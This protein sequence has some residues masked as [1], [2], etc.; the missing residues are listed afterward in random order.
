MK[1][2]QRLAVVCGMVI[3]ASVAGGQ[4]NAEQRSKQGDAV[5][6]ARQELL[7]AYGRLPL[8]LEPNLGQADPEISFISRANGYTLL[9]TRRAEA[10]LLVEKTDQKP[11]SA[12]LRDK[13]TEGR[14]YQRC[15]RELLRL[16]FIGVKASPHAEA[17]EQLSGRAN[18]FIG[19]DPHKWRTNVPLYGRVKMHD[20]YPGID[21]AYYGNQQQLEQDI[22]VA[23]GADLSAVSMIAMGAKGLSLDQ[24]GNLVVAMQDGDVLLHKPVAYQQIQGSR[25]EVPAT[26]LL[27]AGNKFNFQVA[28][29]DHSHALVIDPVLTYS[30][31]VGGSQRDH[32]DAIAVDS[33]GSAYITGSTSSSDFPVAGALQG[34]LLNSSFGNAFVTKFNAT[35]SALVYSTYLGGTGGEQG[36]GI[37]VDSSGNAYVSGSTGSTDF[38]TTSGAFQT[39]PGTSYVA[40]LNASGSALVYSTYLGNGGGVTA[41]SI[42]V[43][44]S[45]Q[46]FVTGTAVLGYL[47]TT[48][49]AFQTNPTAGFNAFVTKFNSTGTALVYSTYLG[50]SFFVTQGND[51]AIDSAGNAYLTG[52]TF[53]GSFPTTANAFQSVNRSTS[54]GQNAFVSKLNAS[55]SALVWSTYLGGTV[56]DSG[57][58]VAADSS[59][60]AYVTGLANSPDF[61]TTAGSFLTA[62]PVPGTPVGFVSKL[63]STGSAL[64]YST[65]LGGTDAF[66]TIPHR[67][68]VD[69]SANAYV[70]GFTGQAT[71]PVTAN[72]VQATLGGDDDSF[73]TTL[74]PSG[75][76]LVFSSY[77]GGISEDFGADIAL[78]SA[79]SAYIAGSTFSN[80]GF[81]TTPGAFASSTLGQQ[82]GFVAKIADIAP[83]AQLNNLTAEVIVSNKLHTTAIDGRFSP[84]GSIDPITQSVF[85]SV[86]GSNNFAV[87]FSPGSFKRV[88][89]G[90]IASALS[91]SRK[92]TMLLVPLKNGSWSYSALIVGFVPGS[93]PVTVSLTVG[94]QSGSATVTARVF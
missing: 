32:A 73:V 2:Y 65:Y 94:S 47:P 75:T 15:S 14:T 41:N 23:P 76:A 39:T 89:G 40:K 30:T 19:S 6:A 10:V 45:G 43:D 38:P 93:N 26:Y 72:A 53:D 92:I 68:R 31:L 34:S 78:D 18:Y 50:G 49:G 54:S 27:T 88:F 69:S 67:I 20:L 7:R 79:G 64:A 22:I 3:L 21:V 4:V 77:L 63:S 52:S 66:E 55:G 1:T 42:A 29:Y 46:A 8:H 60:N 83:P 91:G 87:T 35:G 24:A 71:F 74:N 28:A 11:Q 59:G 17:S 16:A 70:T 82:A 58:G 13:L 9:L 48:L 51:I 25:R 33:S 86:A 85:V 56:S 12:T 61:P 80:D 57:F 36:T 62:N 37:A 5:A 81:P 44:S 84:A 90:Y